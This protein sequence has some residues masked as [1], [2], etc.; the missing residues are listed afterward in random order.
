LVDSKLTEFRALSAKVSDKTASEAERARW[1]TLRAE[2][3]Q[4]APPELPTQ[5]PRAHPRVSRKLRVHYATVAE[6][7][8][9]FTDEIGGGGLRLRTHKILEAGA[10]M[11]VHLD[12]PDAKDAPLTLEARVVWSKREGGHYL[13]GLELVNLPPAEAERLAALLHEKP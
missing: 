10:P 2:L 6:M 7:S 1:R 9:T 4:P 12:V 3:A 5:T 8:M 11:V 13:V